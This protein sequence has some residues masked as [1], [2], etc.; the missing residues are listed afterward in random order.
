MH[1]R[2]F[3][4]AV[5][6]W[7][8]ASVLASR[9]K[10]IGALAFFVA[11]WSAIVFGPGDAPAFAQ[12][13]MTWGRYP[14][15]LLATVLAFLASRQDAFDAR[16]RLAWTCFASAFA[17]IAIGDVVWGWLTLI[18][19]EVA[20]FS[21]SN[22]F[23][24]SYFPL[25]LAGL[26]VTPRVFRS[27]GDAQ[28][29]VLDALTVA[30]AAGMVLWYAALRPAIAAAG[31]VPW[32]K[33]AMALAYPIG[34]MLTVLGI[35][36][37]LLRQPGGSARRVAGWLALSM[38]CS[39]IGDTAWIFGRVLGLAETQR[40]SHL[41]WLLQAAFFLAAARE[42][43]RRALRSGTRAGKDREWRDTFRPLPILASVLGF[44]LLALVARSGDRV[45]LDHALVAAAAL[46]ALV[47]ARHLIGQRESALLLEENIRRRG[48]S[49]FAAL[50]EHATDAI[51]IVDAQ[52]RIVYASPASHALVA[53]GA[54]LL[55]SLQA[56][57]RA[58]FADYVAAC[59]DGHLRAKRLILRFGAGA[60][61]ETTLSNLLDDPQVTG[62]VLNVRDVTERHQL[63]EQLRFQSLHDPLSGLPNRDL[64]LD[65]VA[66]ALARSRE[67]EGAIG[68]AMLDLD[69]FK[70]VN[71]GLGPRVGDKVLAVCA[72]RLAAQM[73]G[74]DSVARLGGDEFGVLFEGAGREPFAERLER[75]R[76]ALGHALTVD[77][78]PVRLTASAG[79]ATGNGVTDADALL[80]NAD[81]ALHEAKSAGGDRGEQFR[82]E[83][84]GRAVERLALEAALPGLVEV[85]AFELRFEPILRVADGRPVGLNVRLDWREPARAPAPIGEALDALREAGHGALAGRFALGALEKD[86]PALLRYVPDAAT[87]ALHLRLDSALLRDAGFAEH[88][89]RLVAKLD[90]RASN[91][92]FELEERSLRDALEPVL[93]LRGVGAGLALADFGAKHATFELLDV[94]PFDVLVL[95]EPLVARIESG[96]RPG[97]LVRAAV[98]TG[99]ALGMRIVAPGVRNERQA[100]LLAKLGCDQAFGDHFAA[101]MPYERVLTWLAARFAEA[102]AS[103]S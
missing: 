103:G 14:V 37:I 49:R 97:A 72:S 96:E 73:T 90:L 32:F 81:I 52:G 83:R 80:R 15:L 6:R 3:E 89:A 74:A 45:A 19:G 65:R 58:A 22:V 55:E 75:M 68:V 88:V 50:I 13:V 78:H 76:V 48:E 25:M 27:R 59:R 86:L 7:A 5:P 20:T 43:L 66:R 41:L 40:V 23:F 69:R 60:V 9:R 28:T 31:D 11:L 10:L 16:T 4:S 67:G 56:D 94:V 8:R 34:D 93:A 98:A 99:R 51:L 36:L 100:A 70:L 54:D 1:D 102:K 95:A 35:A 17:T 87:L 92:V 79:L 64:F 18:R 33:T 62:I 24:L 101:P 84:H 53:P 63:E 29:F 85:G 38:L 71:D 91:F 61:T 47:V 2:R 57:D 44:V 12:V 42:Q 46:L 39:L 77:G 82:A 26:L 21:I 30:V